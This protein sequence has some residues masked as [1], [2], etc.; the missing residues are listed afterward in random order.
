LCDF[1][2]RFYGNRAFKEYASYLRQGAFLY[3]LRLS[4]ES[5]KNYILSQEKFQNTLRHLGGESE[6]LSQSAFRMFNQTNEQSEKTQEQVESMQQAFALSQEIAVGS[7]KIANL[8]HSVKNVV[9][10]AS[11][12][13]EEGTKSVLHA[14][15]GMTDLKKQVE[16]IAHQMK[17][18][19]QSSG[20]IGNIIKII[21]DISEQTNILSLNAAIEAVGAGESGKRFSV[22]ASEVRRLAEKTVE[23]T[24]QIKTIIKEMQVSTNNTIMVTEAV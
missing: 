13:C 10:L 1:F 11:G 19:G 3:L 4:R 5:E 17:G 12:A 16:D 7:N 8:A 20:K 23:A 15:D 21:E 18:L 24:K 22:V 6:K 14:M 9:D 2:E